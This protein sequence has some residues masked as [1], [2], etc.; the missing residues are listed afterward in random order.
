MYIS[1]FKFSHSY[2]NH[3]IN[4]QFLTITLNTFE[5]IDKKL[6][7]DPRKTL[8]DMYIYFRVEL[9]FVALFTYMYVYF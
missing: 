6:H 8:G 4:P 7:N 5:N 1:H 2:R 9:T 3:V